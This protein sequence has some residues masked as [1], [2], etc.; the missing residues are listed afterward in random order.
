LEAAKEKA[1]ELRAEEMSGATIYDDT[2]RA[3]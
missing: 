1:A 2:G 3:R